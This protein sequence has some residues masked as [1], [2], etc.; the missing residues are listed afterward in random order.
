MIGDLISVT[1][2]VCN[3]LI[4][5]NNPSWIL[6]PKRILFSEDHAQF[7]LYTHFKSFCFNMQW[8]LLRICLE[9]TEESNMKREYR[10]THLTV[11][12]QP[13]YLK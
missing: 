6:V 5:A 7:D 1:F 13:L 10:N 12:P 4:P 8:I 11:H 3:I 2:T 9:I